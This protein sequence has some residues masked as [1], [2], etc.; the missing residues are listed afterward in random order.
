MIVS[1]EFYFLIYFG[2]TLF[3]RRELYNFFYLISRIINIQFQ[4]NIKKVESFLL[5]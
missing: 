4:H 1:L 3:S 5:L 2:I